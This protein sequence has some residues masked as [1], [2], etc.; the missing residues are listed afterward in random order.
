[1]FSAQAASSA[2]VTSFIT[3][4]FPNAFATFEGLITEDRVRMI[5][6]WRYT[7]DRENQQVLSLRDA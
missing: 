5:L 1:M 2:T 6:S 4:C 3:R 7:G